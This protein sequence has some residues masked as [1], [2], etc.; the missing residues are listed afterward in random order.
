[1]DTNT[2]TDSLARIL[3]RKSACPARLEVGAVCRGVRH[4]V[5]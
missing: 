5:G 4:T 1:M 3:T 2:D